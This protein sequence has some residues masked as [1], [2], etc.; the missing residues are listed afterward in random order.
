MQESNT[1]SNRIQAESSRTQAEIKP[2][3]NQNPTKILVHESQPNQAETKPKSS[4]TP[5]SQPAEAESQPALRGGGGS[6]HWAGK[7]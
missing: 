5:R 1:K 6:L 4:R 2:K 3:S 7:F